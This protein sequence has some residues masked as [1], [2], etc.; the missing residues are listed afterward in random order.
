VAVTFT[1]ETLSG[2]NGAQILFKLRGM[3]WEAFDS[4]S[5]KIVNSTYPIPVYMAIRTCTSRF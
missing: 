3:K 5:F 2:A 1:M 4:L